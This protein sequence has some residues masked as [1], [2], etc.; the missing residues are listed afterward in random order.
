[1]SIEKDYGLSPD[2]GLLFVVDMSINVTKLDVKHQPTN[3]PICKSGFEPK[4]K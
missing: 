2:S 1:M 3:Q 4:S